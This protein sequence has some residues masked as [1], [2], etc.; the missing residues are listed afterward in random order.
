YGDD[1]G[2]TR[3][4]ALISYSYR[5]KAPRG[6]RANANR[7]HKENRRKWE[8]EKH[9]VT[10]ARGIVSFEDKRILDR[11]SHVIAVPSRRHVLLNQTSLVSVSRWLPMKQ[12]SHIPSPRV[13]IS[14]LKFR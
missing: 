12:T 13:F 14:S 10:S 4:G 11:S 2:V 3:L 6:H 7:S 8:R 1:K 9:T 5:C